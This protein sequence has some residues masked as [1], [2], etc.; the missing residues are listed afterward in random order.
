MERDNQKRKGSANKMKKWKVI[1][2][3]VTQ[4][5]VEVMAENEDEAIDKAEQ[6]DG[7]EWSRTP[8]VE[9]GTYCAQKR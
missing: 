2:Q 8:L 3:S 5:E 4:Y 6:I 9:I 1:A 7:A